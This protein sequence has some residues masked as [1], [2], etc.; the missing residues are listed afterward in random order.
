MKLSAGFSKTF[1]D[2]FVGRCLALGMDEAETTEVF[3]KYANNKMLSTP[4]IYEGFRQRLHDEEHGMTKAAMAKYLTP[5][6]LSLVMDCRIKYANDALSSSMRAHLDLPEPA[7]SDVPPPTRE[8]AYLMTK[9]AAQLLNQYSQ[10]PMN[11]QVLLASLVGGGMGGLKRL[12]LPS[13]EDRMSNRSALNRFGRGAGR[14]AVVGAG[15]GMGAAA[16]GAMFPRNRMSGMLTG[17]AVGGLGA[18]AL[19]NVV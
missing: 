9:S 13:M 14:G 6:V 3:H 19:T 1:L 8:V 15:A 16:G 18:N 12:A 7:W 10:L 17:G 4:G 11:Q 2:G 5:E